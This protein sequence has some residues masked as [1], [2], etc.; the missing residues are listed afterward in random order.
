MNVEENIDARAQNEHWQEEKSI[1]NC[2]Q[3][4]N[5]SNVKFWEFYWKIRIEMFSLSMVNDTGKY[6]SILPEL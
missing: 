2:R 6:D 4:K 3:I 5:Y 1:L